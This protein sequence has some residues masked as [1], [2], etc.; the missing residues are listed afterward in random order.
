MNIRDRQYYYIF[1]RGRFRI[2]RLTQNGTSGFGTY[3]GEEYVSRE[4]A[5]QR[6]YQL[7]GW[8]KPGKTVCAECPDAH[9]AVNGRFCRILKA[10]VEY[11]KT[12]PCK[13]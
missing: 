3:T 12:P 7:N 5:R 9:N 8:D 6:V 10:Y 4:Q 2:H 11:A 1:V 13:R